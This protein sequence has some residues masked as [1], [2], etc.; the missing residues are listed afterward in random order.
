MTD[1]SRAWIARRLA[2][3]RLPRVTGGSAATPLERASPSL[4]RDR[5]LWLKR[6]DTHQLGSFKWRGALPVLARLAADGAEAVVTASTGNHAAATAWAASRA[7]L[8][9]VVFVPTS[10]SATKVALAASFGAEL[11]KVGRDLDEAKETAFAYAESTGIPFFED[12]VERAQYDGYRSVAAEVLDQLDELPAAVVVP[13]GNGAL[14]GG[15]GME[16]CERCPEAE[17]IGVAAAAAPV[18]AESWSA[19]HPVSSEQADTFADGLAVRVAIPFAV[20]VLGEV[21][22][23]ML[24]VSEH[25]IASA[26]AAYAEAGIRVEGAGAASYAALDQIEQTDGPIVLVVTG[27]NIDDE[28]FRR[29]TEAPDTFAE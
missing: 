16:I 29:A 27:R 17:R 9:A 22:S 14:L 19:G 6:E 21:A 24:V 20:S 15:I 2:P 23:R 28:L 3:R 10:A 11:R 25:A 18:M 5:N 1:A 8:R 12:G 7:G 26:V 4:A 13:V